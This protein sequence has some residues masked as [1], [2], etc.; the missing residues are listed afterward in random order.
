MADEDI[1]KRRFYLYMGARLFGLLTFLAGAAI[2]FT[3]ILREGGSTVVGAVIMAAGL[4]DAVIAPTLMK[5]Q[6]RQQDEDR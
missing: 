2:M 5:K 3:D 6:W 1:W 4:A